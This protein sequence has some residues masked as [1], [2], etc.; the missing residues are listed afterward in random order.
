MNAIGLVLVIL[1]ALD[2][3]ICWLLI[4]PKVPAHQRTLVATVITLTSFAMVGFGIATTL[5]LVE[6]T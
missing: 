1:G 4:L 6:L 5:G 3:G 2:F